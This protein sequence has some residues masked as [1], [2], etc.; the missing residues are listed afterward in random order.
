MR[1]RLGG[2]L[3][4]ALVV[5]GLGLA[6]Y[7]RYWLAIHTDAALDIPVSLSRGHIRTGGFLIND[8]EAHSIDVLL[9]VNGNTSC[10]ALRTVWSASRNGKPIPKPSGK[11]FPTSGCTLG[12][13]TDGPGRYE[14]DVEVVSDTAPLDAIQ[15]RLQIELAYWRAY[16]D[17]VD[18]ADC[19]FGFGIFLA[20]IGASLLLSVALRPQCPMAAGPSFKHFAAASQPF[21]NSAPRLPFVG[22]AFDGATARVRLRGHLH[23]RF[24]GECAV[25]S[26]D[27]VLRLGAAG[28][29]GSTG[30]RTCR[31]GWQKRGFS[32]T[33]TTP[34]SSTSTPSRSRRK[35]C[36]PRSKQNW[37]ASRPFGLCRR[38]S[39]R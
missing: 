4:I 1:S 17:Y 29:P 35:S 11:I 14:L 28:A 21:A 16:Y 37:P 3:G 32:C 19:L 36:H 7:S 5:G 30:S 38:R 25:L 10:E 22:S 6:A 39:G 31:S 34:E 15:P 2:W 33:S 9:G 13:L 8:D 18:A 24:F 12:V 20:T 27:L 23:G 26:R